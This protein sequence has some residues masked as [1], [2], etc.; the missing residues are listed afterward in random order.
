DKHQFLKDGIPVTF[1]NERG[2]IVKNKKLKLF[3]FS[4]PEENEYLAV[5]QLWIEG[6]SK[7][8]RRPDVVGFVNGIPLVFIELK[9][10]H[11]KI[12]VAFD[13]NLTDYKDTIPHIFFCNA[14]IILS[15][16][17]ESRIGSLTS[18]FEH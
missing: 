8:R 6:K 12:R 2:E 17:I 7:R 11:R 1:K 14:F 4:N 10:H 16:G 18:R 3:D 13:D 15:N 5:Q 9:A